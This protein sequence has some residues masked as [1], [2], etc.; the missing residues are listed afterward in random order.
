MTETSDGDLT[1]AGTAFPVVG[2]GASAGGVEALSTFFAA[3]PADSGMAY[4]VVTHVGPGH[5]AVLDEILG[6]HAAIPILRA[7]TARPS[8]RPRLC[9]CR[10]RPS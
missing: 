4:V 7:P 9:R 5:A 10:P 8:A 3:V 6:R 2:L 1:D